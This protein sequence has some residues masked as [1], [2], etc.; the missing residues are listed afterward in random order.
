LLRLIATGVDTLTGMA[1]MVDSRVFMDMEHRRFSTSAIP[2]IVPPEERLA[3]A[4]ISVSV[5]LFGAYS[6]G[7][8]LLVSTGH[9]AGGLW[10]NERET[11]SPEEGAGWMRGKSRWECSRRR[12]RR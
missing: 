11:R 5:L 12:R 7:S 10:Y 8:S 1:M 2:A 4:A 3:M 6:Y 9:T